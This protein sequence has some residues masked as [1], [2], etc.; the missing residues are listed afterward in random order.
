MRRR[1]SAAC[2][3]SRHRRP[4]PGAASARPACGGHPPRPP[5]A[6]GGGRPARGLGA[7]CPQ[8]GRAA[9]SIGFFPTEREDEDCLYLNVWTGSLDAMA[10]RPVMVW[11]HG[12]AFYLGSGAVPLFDGAALARQG[13]VV[14]TVNY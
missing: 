9:R 3:G 2:A 10:R 6:G 14:V 1:Q 5:P 8:P 11:F 13:A 4:P 12:G 7:R